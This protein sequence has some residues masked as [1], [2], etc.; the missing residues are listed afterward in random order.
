VK[1]ENIAG[2]TFGCRCCYLCI[3]LLVTRVSS[4]AVILIW[5]QTVDIN[6]LVPVCP[7]TPVI[8]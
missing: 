5:W 1:S 6:Q 8:A 4:A 7:V 3:S 2:I